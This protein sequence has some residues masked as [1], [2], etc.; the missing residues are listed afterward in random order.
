MASDHGHAEK[1][2]CYHAT[3]AVGFVSCRED[4]VGVDR[5][6]LHGNSTAG[7]RPVLWKSPEL[8][9]AKKAG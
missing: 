3:V 1:S 5:C 2:A 4:G 8:V 9:A 7:S 6:V